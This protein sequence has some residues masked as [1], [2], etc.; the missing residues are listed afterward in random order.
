MGE[1][2]PWGVPA[3]R[4]HE[5]ENSLEPIALCWRSAN[6]TRWSMEFGTTFA[7]QVFNSSL[8]LSSREEPVG[9]LIYF[10]CEPWA[11]AQHALSLNSAPSISA[12]VDGR[13]RFNGRMPTRIRGLVTGKLPSSPAPSSA[14][15]VGLVQCNALRVLRQGDRMVN[16]KGSQRGTVP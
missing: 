10:S 7:I 3:G 13:P 6:S 5:D 4:T 1:L 8:T 15:N 14:T 12:L 9:L 2:F 16:M 11:V